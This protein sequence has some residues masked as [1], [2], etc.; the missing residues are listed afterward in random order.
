MLVA[1]SIANLSRRCAGCARATPLRVAARA[2][3]AGAGV[4]CAGRAG[5]SA[6]AECSSTRRGS[7]GGRG[8]RSADQLRLPAAP[9]RC[10]R[11]GPA[12]GRRSAACARRAPAHDQSHL[13][14]AILRS[15]QINYKSENVA[16][17]AVA[18]GRDARARRGAAR[19][20]ARGGRGGALEARARLRGGYSCSLRLLLIKSTFDA[21]RGASFGEIRR[22]R[23]GGRGEVCPISTGEGTRRVRLVPRREGGR[24]GA[25]L[26]E[27]GRQSLRGPPRG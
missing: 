18:G 15:V 6:R 9:L 19:V 27:E 26:M 13:S 20:A 4:T 25:L 2:P 24:R 23:T 10:R 8:S 21:R 1:T 12:A 5:R 22:S 11:H 3:G 16:A 7:C 17:R 14:K